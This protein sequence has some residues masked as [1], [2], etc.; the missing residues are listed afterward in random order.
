MTKNPQSSQDPVADDLVCFLVDRTV[1]TVLGSI[2]SNPV[3]YGLEHP[4]CGN[5]PLLVHR[6]EFV[7]PIIGA[8]HIPGRPRRVLCKD[9]RWMKEIRHPAAHGMEDAPIVATCWNPTFIVNGERDYVLGLPIPADPYVLNKDG[10]CH[11]F[12]KPT[13]EQHGPSDPAASTEEPKP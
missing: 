12:E 6:D 9:C 11:G 13:S 2:P 3:I 5:S 4:Q 1:C 8:I 7:F 10:Y